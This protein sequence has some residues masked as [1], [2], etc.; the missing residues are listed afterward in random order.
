[1]KYS[2]RYQNLKKTPEFYDSKKQSCYLYKKPR[3]T[4]NLYL[5]DFLRNSAMSNVVHL[6]R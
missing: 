3:L 6:D 1:M 5:H 4:E 2:N